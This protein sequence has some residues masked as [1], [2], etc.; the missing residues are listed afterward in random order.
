MGKYHMRKQ[1]KQITD[2]NELKEILARGKYAVISMCRDNEPYIVTLSYGYDNAD[3]ALYFHT[4]QKGLK[5][6]FIKQ[7]PNVCA[8]VIEDRG[9]M[10]DECG[11]DYRSVVIFGRISL[12]E[13]IQEKKHGLEVILNHLEENPEKFK[14]KALK[15]DDVY[16]A[17]AVLKLEIC[18]ISGKKGR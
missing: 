14:E 15:S 16:S 13:N 18:D 4:G 12:I 7:N 2:E 3:N 8:T 5:I 17:I 9:Y 1:E 6:D 10:K 11:H